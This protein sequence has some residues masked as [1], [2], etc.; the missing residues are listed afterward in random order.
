MTAK[1]Q[2]CSIKGSLLKEDMAEIWA[3]DVMQQETWVTSDMDLRSQRGGGLL[4]LGKAA[5]L[6]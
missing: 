3:G 1:V 4:A 6:I 5:L 2:P